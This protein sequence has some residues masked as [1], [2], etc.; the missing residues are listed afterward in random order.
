[1]LDLEESQLRLWSQS[2]SENFAARQELWEGVQLYKREL[3]HLCLGY[4][5]LSQIE[6]L[7]HRRT[8]GV[9]RGW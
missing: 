1:L 2:Q 8:Y 4:H 5:R 9:R 3:Y 6:E 7:E